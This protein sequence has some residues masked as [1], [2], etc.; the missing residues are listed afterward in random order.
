MKISDCMKKHVISSVSEVSIIDGIRIMV[1]NHIGTL[2]IVNNFSILVGV[3]NIRNLLELTTPDFVNF[4]DNIDFVHDFGAVENETPELEILNKPLSEIMQAPITV[5]ANAG[6]NRTISMFHE[7]RLT[8]LPV[9]DKDMRL[10]GIV[11]YVDIGLNVISK[12]NL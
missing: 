4:I 3:V 12:W 7:H 9:V 5:E 11:S 10:V 2:P 1:K 6:L 8:D